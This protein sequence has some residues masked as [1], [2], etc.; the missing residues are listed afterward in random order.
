[1]LLGKLADLRG[2]EFVYD[3][4]SYLPLLGLLAAFLPDLRAQRASARAHAA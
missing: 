1:V 3:V 4:C 2:I